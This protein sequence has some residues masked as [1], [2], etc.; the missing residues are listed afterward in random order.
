MVHKC[1]QLADKK[2]FYPWKNCGKI[3][4]YSWPGPEGHTDPKNIF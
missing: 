3:W 4:V 1:T 2:M